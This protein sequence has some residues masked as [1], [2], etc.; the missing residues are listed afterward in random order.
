[1]KPYVTLTTE[2]R[3]AL[4]NAAWSVI[5]LEPVEDAVERII[6]ARLKVASD[7][8]EASRRQF[9][10]EMCE[11]LREE[12]TYWSDRA[13]RWTSPYIVEQIEALIYEYAVVRGDLTERR[14]REQLLHKIVALRGGGA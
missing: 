3:E 7:E 8:A 10:D 1:M 14:A 4:C 6:A 11:R 9:T 5:A 2:E 12:V 13:G